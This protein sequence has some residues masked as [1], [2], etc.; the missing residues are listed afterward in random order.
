MTREEL[1]AEIRHAAN[2]WMSDGYDE[3]PLQQVVIECVLAALEGHAVID[4]Q[5]RK[6]GRPE[7]RWGCQPS[8]V[9]TD[10]DGPFPSQ[11]AW[12]RPDDTPSE[13]VPLYTV[14]MSR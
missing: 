4:G 9:P 14:G 6:L 1:A 13:N 2:T 12:L 5:P 11:L 10:V 3:R 7:D 8:L